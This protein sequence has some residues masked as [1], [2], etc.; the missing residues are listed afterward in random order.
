MH[1]DGA[2]AVLGQKVLPHQ[3][4]SIVRAAAAEQASRVTVLINKP[5]GY[6]GGQAEDGYEPAVVWFARRT[7][8]VR[9]ARRYAF[10]ASS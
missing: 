10:S 7:A 9:I 2:P 5:I 3:K 8:G 1:V 4:I 6:V